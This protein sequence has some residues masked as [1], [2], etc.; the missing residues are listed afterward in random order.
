M[1]TQA[2]SFIAR[3]GL[4]LTGGA[5][6]LA[7]CGLAGGTTM[8]G[9]Q[10][11]NGWRTHQDQRGF[12]VEAPRAWKI[13]A[14]DS[15]RIDLR[16]GAEEHIVIWPVLLQ[17]QINGAI[18]SSALRS[19]A[20]K[21]RPDVEW[22]SFEPGSGNWR[23]LFGRVGQQQAIAIFTWAN[24]ADGAAGVVYTLVAPAA[25]YRQNTDTYARILQSFRVTGEASANASPA[26]ALL[27][28]ERWQDPLENAFSLDVPRGW[29]AQGGAFRF[30][31]MDVRFTVV[32]LS[33]DK[34]I[35]VTRGDAELPTFALPSDA[36]RFIGNTSGSV[37]FI[38]Y[39]A[40][41]KDYLS[42]AK[43]AREYVQTK[44]TRGCTNLQFTNQRERPDLVQAINAIYA[45]YAAQG[46]PIRY[47]A[48]EV[49]FTCECSGQAR[50]GYY[51]AATWFIRGSTGGALW[52]VEHLYG[53]LATSAKAAEAQAAL[54]RMAR[55]GQ[56]NPEWA[57]RQQGLT[58]QTVRIGTAM[59]RAVSE[60]MLEN[61]WS[62][63]RSRD[64]QMRRSVNAIAGTEDVVDPQTGRQYNIYSGSNY[65]WI[66]RGDAIVGTN[67]WQRPDTDFRELVR[68]P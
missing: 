28:Y 48:G 38:G 11:Q 45:G 60:A 62:H 36:D 47:E 40:F 57:A 64:E 17:A 42:G 24:Q 58:N 33:P 8:F 9:Q 12:A 66:D 30:A 68:L 54:Q 23:R 20:M 26:P 52:A 21:I 59:I 18:A 10:S 49:A 50:Q 1:K 27:S 15:G 25:R 61:Y 46:V 19:V 4:W 3:L 43:F 41:F 63:T 22:Q 65:Y 51:L 34:Q 5:L 31:S 53:Y 32:A 14:A 67:T 16:G 56:T 35:R 29:S 55:S 13:V 44:V 2:S 6:C 7:G 39:R 37:D